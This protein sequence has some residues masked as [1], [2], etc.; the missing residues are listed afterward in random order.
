[1]LVGFEDDGSGGFLRR[2]FEEMGRP[3]RLII[4]P[5]VGTNELP[6]IYSAADGFVFPSRHEN[7]GNVAIEAMACGCPVVMSD[8]VGV[9]DQVVGLPGVTVLP[10]NV[11]AWVAGLSGLMKRRDEK[12]NE[13]I[14][15]GV[16]EKF[17]PSQ[18][19]T[20]ME[21]AYSRV[22]DPIR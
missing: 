8:Q 2:K 7:F 4:L 6:A 3:D 15:V 20:K 21:E 13:L 12:N 11:K 18:V 19:A 10:L 14:R 1:V 22:L 17:S 9:A 5:G 16:V